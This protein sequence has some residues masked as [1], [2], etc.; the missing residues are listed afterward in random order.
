MENSK[1]YSYLVKF[2]SD[3]LKMGNEASQHIQ[4]F[5]KLIRDHLHPSEK[6]IDLDNTPIHLDK[7]DHL[8]HPKIQEI[9]TNNFV[10]RQQQHQVF[11]DISNCIFMMTEEFPDITQLEMQKF[12][13]DNKLPIYLIPVVPSMTNLFK[14]IE[15]KKEFLWGNKTDCEYQLSVIVTPN[16]Q[17]LKEE[18]VKYGF[19][20]LEEITDEYLLKSGFISLDYTE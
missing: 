19:D 12:L 8:L 18:I 14:I 15:E 10:I 7:I 20:T 6:D 11:F 9:L 17:Y 4:E 5:R 2:V 3:Y 1:N 16:K 13:I